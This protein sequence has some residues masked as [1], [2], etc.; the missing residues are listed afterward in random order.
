MDR[1][2]GTVAFL[3]YLATQYGPE[4]TIG[5]VFNA[6]RNI[7]RS[8]RRLHEAEIEIDN[9]DHTGTSEAVRPPSLVYLGKT[10]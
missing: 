5:D 2:F 6:E 9:S 3:K 1:I 8:E 7:A 10:A 4:A